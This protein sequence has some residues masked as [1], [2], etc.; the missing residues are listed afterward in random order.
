ML[1]H[2]RYEMLLKCSK[3]NSL[4][5]QFSLIVP[6]FIKNHYVVLDMKYL[7][8]QTR[9]QSYVNF[10]ASAKNVYRLLRKFQVSNR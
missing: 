6:N 10:V 5:L 4:P 8:G 3:I 7:D 1:P 2:A 9:L